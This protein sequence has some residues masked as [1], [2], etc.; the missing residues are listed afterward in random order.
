MLIPSTTTAPQYFTKKRNYSVVGGDSFGKLS[1]EDF[2]EAEMISSGFRSNK[3]GTFTNDKEESFCRESLQEQRELKYE[4]KNE[5]SVGYWTIC[6]LFAIYGIS[7]SMLIPALP[8]LILGLTDYNSS[9]ASVLY[10]LANFVRHSLEFFA[11]PVLGSLADVKGRRPVLLLSF[12]ICSSEFMLLAW[13]PCIPM[14][15]LTRAVAGVFDAGI[16]MSFAVVSD[17]AQHRGDAVAQ[18][19]G[20]LGAMTGLS[21]VVG[22]F[23]GGYL[24]DVSPR[25]CF[26]VASL[27]SVVGAVVCYVFLPETNKLRI[28]A[29]THSDFA[30]QSTNFGY[31]NSEVSMNPIIGLRI[32]LSSRRLRQFS[33]PLFLCALAAGLSFVTYIYMAA[34]LFAS[35]TQIGL[36]LAF[37]GVLSAVAQGLFIKYLVPR[38]ISEGD[39]ALYA[40]I[41]S[42]LQV[43]TLAPCS[44]LWQFYIVN[45]VFFLSAIHYPAL[46]ALMVAESLRQLDAAKYQAN[47]QGAI[48]S[49]RTLATALGSLLFPALYT[50]GKAVRPREM[51]YLPFVAAGVLYLSSYFYLRL[52]LADEIPS[53]GIQSNEM[54]SFHEAHVNNTASVRYHHSYEAILISDDAHDEQKVNCF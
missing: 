25:L 2:M 33:L 8:S 9:T 20:V 38:F 17:I 44:H 21:F 3:G 15:F 7:F 50:I 47:L 10:G 29:A 39:A 35:S 30:R 43:L 14:V 16:P 45:F 4:N 22:P 1:K 36:Y 52:V 6:I 37:Y 46:K 18:Q 32:H 27:V 5:G 49:I 42:G 40:L 41:L 11:S 48:S 28:D 19:F 54:G 31:D 24:T 26:I 53:Y 23:L 12:L 51:A 34:E 13:Y